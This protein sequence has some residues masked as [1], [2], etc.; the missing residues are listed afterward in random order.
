MQVLSL[1]EKNYPDHIP[2][3]DLLGNEVGAGSDGQVFDIKGTNKVIKY[4]ILYQD[5]SNDLHFKF[6]EIMKAICNIRDY[7]PNICARVYEFDFIA[8]G[9]RRVF[10]GLDQKYVMYYYIMEKLSKISE[11]EKKVFHTILSHEDRGII[12]NFKDKELKEILFGLSRGLDFDEE[13]V[14][15]FYNNLKNSP[16]QHLDIHVRNIMKDSE[17]NYR[18]ID[19]DRVNIRRSFK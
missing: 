5:Y 16:I 14:I 8:Y 9:S 10:R 6:E 18:L 2:Y 15:I 3:Y 1:Y 11:D 17:G 13:R 4:C 7:N 12:K 19:F